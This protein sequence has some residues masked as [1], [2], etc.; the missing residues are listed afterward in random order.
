MST[1]MED[2]GYRIRAAHPTGSRLSLAHTVSG[3]DQLWEKFGE[4]SCKDCQKAGFV[5][6]S[7]GEQVRRIG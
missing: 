6:L 5:M 7:V 2:E 1:G 3:R 4:A